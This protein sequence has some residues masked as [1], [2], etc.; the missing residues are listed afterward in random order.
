MR[1]ICGARVI[2]S[3]PLGNLPIREITP[4][5]LCNQQQEEQNRACE[6][7]AQSSFFS[8]FDPWYRIGAYDRLGIFVWGQPE[9]NGASTENLKDKQ[10]FDVYPDGTLFFP[11]IGKLPVSG[12]TVEE[13]RLLLT[14]RLK[15]LLIDPVVSVTVAEYR[16][17]FVNVVGEVNLPSQ[18]SLNDV[19]LNLLDAISKAGGAT[20]LGDLQTVAI[21]RGCTTAEFNL[22]PLKSCCCLPSI[23]LQHG[24]IIY[25]PS[26][27]NREVYVFGEVGLPHS[28]IMDSDTVTLSAALARCLGFDPFSSNPEL[29]FVF[30]LEENGERVAYH[31]N[32]RSPAALLLASEFR[33]KR[34]DVIYVGTYRPAQLNRVMTNFLSLTRAVNDVTRSAAY[35]N[36]VINKYN[37]FGN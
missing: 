13:V 17:Q 32:A 15:S 11:M 18:V 1:R 7:A 9:L 28:V 5:L 36:D 22:L 3:C 10:Y 37:T 19:P 23:Y 30:R 34:Q 16:S 21:R 26:K 12:K 20:P 6:K 2:Q 25:V 27:I 31:L 4:D 29:V 14:E 24:D 35:I 33:L 8:H